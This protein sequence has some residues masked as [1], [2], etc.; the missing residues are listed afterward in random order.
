MS[1]RWSSVAIGALL[2]LITI[3][4]PRARAD[5]VVLV[6]DVEVVRI[7]GPLGINESRGL[8]PIDLQIGEFV[9]IRGLRVQANNQGGTSGE[10]EI[11]IDTFEWGAS[12]LP[13]VRLDT[14]VVIINDFSIV[15]NV[16]QATPVDLF[17]ACC[18]G[19][20]SPSFGELQ[21]LQ[22][23]KTTDA[24]FLR[25]ELSDTLVS[26]FPFSGSQG[27]GSTEIPTEQ[28]SLNYSKVVYEYGAET[29][30]RPMSITNFRGTDSWQVVPVPSS[31]TLL[32]IGSLTLLA[33]GSGGLRKAAQRCNQ[34]RSLYN[35]EGSMK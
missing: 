23:D 20:A 34:G 35:P 9:F 29:D 10:L 14:T 24:E 18:E 16:E 5:F 15:E 8:G 1:A 26:G 13:P 7:P 11:T 17:S 31:L 2:V 27:S 3:P 30:G 4:G 32:G 28:L 21:R 22:V 33:Y 25:I 12:E 19:E 6:D